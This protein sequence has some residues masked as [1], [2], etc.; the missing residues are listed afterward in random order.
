MLPDLRTNQG[1]DLLRNKGYS[2][3]PFDRP[4]NLKPQAK[5][6][7]LAVN[8]VRQITIDQEI[9]IDTAFLMTDILLNRPPEF[10]FFPRFPKEEVVQFCR[11][12]AENRLGGEAIPIASPVC[13]DYPPAGYSLGEGV[14]LTAQ[15]V[16]DRL[17]TMREFFGKRNFPFF[18]QMHVG[19]IEVFDRL[20][21]QASGETTENFLKKTAGSI[22]A[23]QEKIYQLGIE[24][25]IQCGSMLEAFNQAGLDRSVLREANAQKILDHENRKVNRAIEFL[26][27][28]R[29]RLGDFDLV[30]QSNHKPMA[31]AEL[32][33]YATYGDFINGQ[34]VILSQDT[35]NSV[36]A[37]N[38]LRNGKDKLFNPTIYLKPI[39]SI[40]GAYEP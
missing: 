18:I 20:I 11:L 26:V 6:L 31:A 21:L 7:E 40:R 9:I 12:A 37:Y 22:A 2:F 27:T 24:G 38:F 17:T 28:E 16:L 1:I 14:P 4:G 29:V 10:E 39:R 8:T 3:R 36:P 34:A 33:N 23:T 5:T 19:D 30:D 35:L 13:P 15:I 25:I 32:A